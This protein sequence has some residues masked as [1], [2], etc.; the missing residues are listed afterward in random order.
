[1]YKSVVVAL[2]LFGS[3]FIHIS[4]QEIRE[5]KLQRLKQNK[6]ITVTEQGN[7]IIKIEY[8][9]GKTRYK[10]ISDY[11]EPKSMPA[12]DSTVIDLM[13]LDT[14]Q[15]Y[16]KYK[17]W[18]EVPVHSSEVTAPWI[19]DVNKDGLPEIYGDEKYYET[20]FDSLRIKI[21]EYN[22]SDSS[23]RKVFT[24][25][26]TSLIMKGIADI[27]RD[28]YKEVISTP[29]G[30]YAWC[31]IYKR[32]NNAGYANSFS[33]GYYCRT[34]LN[35]P[36]YGDYNR[37]GRTDIL[38]Y[39]LFT[40]GYTVIAEYNPETNRMDSV[41]GFRQDDLY[42]AGFSHAD[43]D[44]DGYDDIVEATVHGKIYVLSYKP[45]TGYLNTWLGEAGTKNAY[46]HT[47]T[48]D[49]DSNGMPEFWVGGDTYVNGIGRTRLTCY[50]TDGQGG[51]I[52]AGRID[53]IGVFSFFAGNLF[54]LDVDKDGREEL[55]LC[56]DGHFLILKFNGSPGHH[57]YEVFFV[58]K[59][60]PIVDW[61]NYYG[62]TLYDITG[63]G[64][65]E[66][67]ISM[68]QVK[69][70]PPNEIGRYYTRIFA[71]DYLVGLPGYT[72]RILGSAELY[73]NYPNPF[74]PTTRIKFKLSERA[75]VRIRVYNILGKEIK[76]LSNKEL[77][78]GLHSIDWDGKDQQGNTQPA[79]VYFIRLSTVNYS[80]TIKTM[81]LK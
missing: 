73:Q 21:F 22:K 27:D 77:M 76:E 13:A 38:Y 28:G 67:L 40:T 62:G 39:S 63:D 74:N 71:P 15:Y 59:I 49:I 24:Y 66:L 11:E 20:P 31:S 9:S 46:L 30:P 29:P 64:K 8:P 75:T 12:V 2:L 72:S 60:E 58:K 57:S 50:E 26:D 48:K 3:S 33:F 4:A 55:C 47:S 34:Q 51:Y 61:G 41:Y 54:S 32:N 37:N 10:D 19:D 52:A 45:G 6:Q 42:A 80:K 44:G 81:L 16:Q 25:S 5:D 56:I 53:L 23:F 1:M 17:L 18:R 69:G 65:Y 36:T 78:A 35:D 7:G 70:Q 14:L 43:I 79:G 68:S